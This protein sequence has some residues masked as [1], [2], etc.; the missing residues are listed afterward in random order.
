L[1]AKQSKK[2][3][4]RKKG[5]KKGRRGSKENPIE[6]KKRKGREHE[7]LW[8]RKENCY[9]GKGPNG[10]CKRDNSR[11]RLEVP[12]RVVLSFNLRG[13]WVMGK[14]TSPPYPLMTQ[15]LTHPAIL[16]VGGYRHSAYKSKHVFWGNVWKTLDKFNFLQQLAKRKITRTNMLLDIKI[17]F[18]KKPML[19]CICWAEHLEYM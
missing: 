17:K 10:K 2:K 19:T 4:K 11:K 16:E 14:P 13:H 7:R 9:K 12:T 8:K 15:P 3:N 18:K 6:R 1:P 5:N